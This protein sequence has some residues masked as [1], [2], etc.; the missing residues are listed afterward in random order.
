MKKE[1]G[2]HLKSLE[3]NFQLH[4]TELEQEW[5]TNATT[6][7]PHLNIKLSLKLLHKLL[8]HNIHKIK[9]ITLP[10]GTH[11]MSHED[12][13]TYYKT[14]TKL[15]KKCDKHSGTTFLPYKMQS[16]MP[17]PMHYTPTTTHT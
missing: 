12:F 10:N 17:D 2:T 1:G 3:A 13:Q 5:I 4:T 16:R 15:E 7:L 8:I 6:E 14:P 9:H 11:L